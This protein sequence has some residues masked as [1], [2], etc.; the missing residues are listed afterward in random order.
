MKKI[1]ITVLLTVLIC[2][3]VNGDFCGFRPPDLSDND[4]FNL[5]V[6]SSY[7]W[8]DI[9]TKHLNVF[10][11]IEF[12]IKT[13]YYLKDLQFMKSF[14]LYDPLFKIDINETIYDYKS[15]GPCTF[16]F[17]ETLK[18]PGRQS[19]Q[20][21]LVWKNFIKP[22]PLYNVTDHNITYNYFEF[23]AKCPYLY[24]VIRDDHTIYCEKRWLGLDHHIIFIYIVIPSLAIGLIILIWYFGYYRK[25]KQQQ[26]E[27]ERLLQNSKPQY[28]DYI[29]LSI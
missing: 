29:Q 18:Y 3:I 10:Q 21:F 15:L 13:S 19:L 4:L 16:R 7:I 23:R 14:K 27:I 6:N 9:T 17:F 2:S 11:E 12:D 8:S 5:V 25:H 22:L 28:A 24:K 26:D 20:I 1:L